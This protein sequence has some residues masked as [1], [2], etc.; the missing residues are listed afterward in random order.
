MSTRRRGRECVL[1]A[2]YAYEQGEQSREQIIAAILEDGS[3]EGNILSFAHNLFKT[4]IENIQKID[5]YIRSLATNWKLNRIAVVDKNIL[6]IA[7][8]EIQYM[9]DIPMKVSI[10]EAIE[11]AKK[12]STYESASFVNGIMDRVLH[13]HEE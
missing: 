12:Y 5:D 7:I 11:M 6:R 9:P 3:L 10:N 8:C 13:D 1:K 4:V 2:L